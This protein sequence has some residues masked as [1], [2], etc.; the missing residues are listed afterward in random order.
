MRSLTAA[1]RITE[2]RA[3]RQLS[4]CRCDVFDRCAD[5]RAASAALIPIQ[6]LTDDRIKD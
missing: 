6:R 1:E 4:E 3:K 2:A 5:C